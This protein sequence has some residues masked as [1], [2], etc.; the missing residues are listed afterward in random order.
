MP[1]GGKKVSKKLKRVSSQSDAKPPSSSAAV[2]TPTSSRSPS[3]PQGPTTSKV[4]HSIF[5]TLLCP[6]PS[7]CT[8]P[9]TMAQSAASSA[10][11]RF[12]L[13]TGRLTHF[14]Q[15]LNAPDARTPT[16]Q[17][18]SEQIR[19]MWLEVESEYRACSALLA[20]EDP[21]G[22][23]EVQDIYDECYAVYEQSL[24]EL[25]DHLQPPTVIPTAQPAVQVQMSNDCR[26]PPCDTEVFS[27]DYQ[28]WPT[29][30]DLFTAIYINNARLTPVEKLYHLNQ[31]TSG[32]AHDIVAQAP[33][34]N[35]GFE[36]AWNH[37][38]ERFQNKRLIL[39]AQLK[40]LFSLPSIRSESGAALKEL[41]RSVHKCITTLQHSE[42]STDS[43]FAD[44]VLVYLITAK[45]PKATV[46]LWEQSVPNK[47]E[48]PTWRAMNKFLE[49]RYLSLEATEDGH[50][51]I[52]PHYNS[53]PSLP[54]PAHR[55]VNSFEG[56]ISN[57]ARTCDLCSR[58]YHP[59]RSC[60]EFLR[61]TVQERSSY[62]Q[63]KQLC[64][65]CFAR[66]HQ[67]R[68]CT[69]AY[70]CSTCSGR[71][72]TLLHRGEQ[73]PSG[74]NCAPSPH[75]TQAPATIQ[76][77]SSSL[78]SSN[79]SAHVQSY[80]ATNVHQ[81]LLGTAIVD[82]CHAGTRYKARA[83]IDSGS[84]ATF[85]TER[86]FKIIRPPSKPSRLKSLNYMTDLP[87]LHLADPSFH[88]SAQI[89]VLIGADILPSILLSGFRSNICGSLLGQETIFGWVLS[90]PVAAD[91]SRIISSFTTK[92]SVSSDVRL[93]KLL[94]R[95]WEVE[96]LPG[97]PTSESDSICEENF[98][99][100]TQRAPDGRYIVT[101][102]FKCP[103]KIDLGYSRPSAH[104]QFLRNEQRLQR[105]LPLKKQY[106][107]VIHEYLELGHMKQVPPSHDS[108]HFY[109]PHHA[110]FKPEST[111]TKVRVVFN[112]SSPSSNGRSL[113][114]V[115]HS[116]PVLQSDLT[117]QI[118]K[119]RVFRYVFNADINKMYRQILVAPQ[120]T[121]YQRIIFR[122]PN[123]D[124]CDY[125]LDTVT[126]GVNCAP[127]LAI[128][129]LRQLAHEVHPS[130]SV[131]NGKRHPGQLHIAKLFDPAGWLAPF[132]IQA[133]MFMQEVWLREL[134]W[135]EDLPGDLPAIQQIHI[136]RWIH[137]C[138]T[139]KVQIHGFCDAS[140][141]A[142][143][144]A[145]YV[146]VERP[147]G[148]FCSLLTAKTRVAPVRTISLPRLE[149]CGAVLLAEL[150]AAILP[151][152]PLDSSQVSFWTDSTIVLAWLH[153]PACEW[154]TFVGNR[155][156]KIAR[157]NS[158]E[159]WSHVRSEDNPADLASRGIGPIDLAGNDMWWHGPAWLRLPQSQW[160]CPLDPFPETDLEKRA[161]KVLHTSSTSSDILSR[162]SDLGRALRVLTY[163]QR[164][165]QRCRGGSVHNSNEVSGA[166]IA[167]ALQA[168]TIAT[169][170]MHYADEHRCLTTK[171]PLPASS[172]LRN[173][174][175]FIDQNGVMR[176]C[177]RVQASASMSYNE[178]HPILLPPASLLVRLLVRFTHHI[179]LHGGNQLVIRLLRATYWIPRL[180]HI[181]KAVIQSCKVCVIHRKR[182][183][184][185]LMG[186]LPS[187]RVTFSRPFTY[188]GVDFAGPFDVKSFIGRACRKTKGY[189][190]VFVC[191]TTKA[192]HLEA[193]SDL[194][195]DT[196]LAAFA[197]FVARRGCPHEV[198]SDNGRNFV[199]AS[200]ALAV[201]LLEAIRTR[202][203]AVYS[204][205]GLSWRF[206]PPGAPHMGGLWEAGVKS[207]KTLFQ[208]SMCTAKYTLEEFATLLSKIEACL[209][210]RPISPMSED[211]NDPLALSPGHFLIGGPL[212]S[213]AEPEIKES[214]SSILNRWQ[215]LQ[216]LN[217]QFC[218]R[219]KTEYLR[220]LHKRTKWQHPTRDLEVGDLVVIKED[221]IP[222][223]EWRLGRVQKTY[224]GPDDKVRVIDLNTV[225]GLIKRPIT[226]VVLLPMESE[227]QSTYS[228][229]LPDP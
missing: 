202:T 112:A 109:L 182:L 132:V 135:D 7:T 16:P 32:E 139:A 20:T 42:V 34:T 26:L 77:T 166:E 59:V 193:T 37:L 6:S 148:I 69:S 145:I 21:D 161:V 52:E 183:Q 64:L 134:G 180:R 169:Q 170:G 194:S 61:L 39:K 160:P 163:V 78:P 174:N 147:N 188:T 199:G 136:P 48:V 149:L 225:R 221:N 185:Q 41:Q 159:L 1:S 22:Q 146:R 186:D 14:D 38:R 224:P 15:K 11:S 118:L 94:T 3:R 18:N 187:T 56:R 201:D 102:P 214:A 100:T 110:V 206:I 191:F 164:F 208:R 120:H 131:P 207:F 119:W 10:R 212:L 106:D 58:S 24:A 226:K 190:C 81:V 99:Q 27:G 175:P 50:P 79:D 5:D 204:Q 54:T 111:T 74:S 107:D 25:N 158:G 83:L 108:G 45:L 98:L 229:V 227:I 129:V 49:E 197:R 217:Q 92:I 71:H 203:S 70:N 87:K 222:S 140:Q 125:E 178:K 115:L 133:K 46:E 176:A 43:C 51:G 101:L 104:A 216:A 105:N 47:F 89:D 196:F 130:A 162:F 66:G 213:V 137:V 128:R 35:D 96:D 171:R 57:K 53:R 36:S 63:Q 28:Q 68:D 84:E 121:P 85:I 142:Y 91:S 179:V 167:A 126:F 184:T 205:Q 19:G 9:G 177:G 2:T 138:P 31:K 17:P 80:C 103:E 55:R 215:H 153:K 75:T 72:H 90:G 73:T 219:W 168:V 123:G 181:V 113:N 223:H 13:A 144:A 12:V 209:N 189:V 143:G 40:I 211:P 93:E 33:L 198:Q 210:S 165:I 220:E 218:S 86:M 65:N 228:R 44:G 82:I 95:F 97:R 127:F 150:S 155:V 76:S 195:T 60:P 152:M 29:F 114:D 67:L 23:V 192:I 200:R 124:V 116:G 117:T 62:I 154:T 157:C 141:R 8:V 151:Q 172:S 4:C 122:N 156:A 173:L 88:R 30:R